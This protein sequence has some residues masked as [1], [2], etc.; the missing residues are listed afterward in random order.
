[1]FF[2]TYHGTFLCIGPGGRLVQRPAQAVA[3]LDELLDL[4]V[5]GLDAHGVGEPARYLR[6]MQGQTGT[7]AIPVATGPLPGH[8]VHLSQDRRTVA[9]AR[10]G[11]FYC[12]L[13][14]DPVLEA[15]RDEALEW[16]SFA[17]LSRQDAADLL[18]LLAHDWVVG[19][20]GRVARAGEIALGVAWRLRV[21]PDCQV[22]LRY[23]LP[24]LDPSR[25]P[26]AAPHALLMQATLLVDGWR[27]ERIH[28]FRPMVFLTAF[29]SPPYLDQAALCVASLLEFGR[30]EGAVHVIS[31]RPREEFLALMPTLPPG[32][33]SVQTVVAQ[34]WVGYVASKYLV[35]D[36][37]EA[38]D[39][40]PLLFLD[41]DTMADADLTPMLAA[42]AAS[43]RIMAPM[44][45][46][47]PL[48]NAVSVGASL[49]QRAGL[50]PRFVRGFNGGTLGIPSLRLA[51]TWL[52]LIRTIIANHIELHG[53]DAFNWV[54]QEVAN[55]V[56]FAAGHFDATT[57]LRWVRF[58]WEGAEHRAD[59]RIGLVHFWPP[60]GPV[61]KQEAMRTYTETLRA[62]GRQAAPHPATPPP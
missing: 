37:P 29:R 53:R 55:Y 30:Y 56:S 8:V 9:I 49:V 51:G 40:Q 50:D 59:Q 16:E 62:A 28:L 7:Q 46:F 5:P 35:L 6:T 15:S 61:S 2:V 22:D 1:M 41:P 11:R 42:I 45:D 20:T 27:V 4:D 33:L 44:E 19:S 12:A 24:F 57:L 32:R 43:P 10:D 34:D 48:A 58:G 47:H 36:A 13:P 39:H 54:D 17:C 38:Q 60:R 25:G 18:R 23:S 52:R 21:G 14:D 3:G 26:E 31:D